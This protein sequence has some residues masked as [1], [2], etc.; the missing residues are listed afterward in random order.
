M[1]VKKGFFLL[2][3]VLVLF[4]V[5]AQRRKDVVLVVD[6]SSSMFSYYNELGTYLSGPFLAQNLAA[7]DTIHIISYGPKPRFEIVRQVVEQGDMETVSARIWLLY[8][9]SP[10]SDPAAALSYTEQYLRTIPGGRPKKVFIVSGDDLSAQVNAAAAR[11]Q[12]G[13]EM[14]FI[15]ASSLMGGSQPAA[16]GN[17]SGRTAVTAPGSS[18]GAAAAAPGSS[19]GTAT[20]APGRTTPVTT[21]GSSVGTAATAP[22][23]S[24]GTAAPAPGRTTPVTTPGSSA[25]TAAA[26]PGSSTGTAAPAPGR[27]TPAATPGSSAGTAAPAPGSS[28]GTAAAAP[29]SNSGRTTPVTAPS[30]S[31]GTAAAAPGSNSG[32]T[33]PAPAP[34]SSTGTAVAAPGSN[35]GRTAVATPDSSTG[36][37][38]A[39]SSGSSGTPAAVPDGSGTT[40][41]ASG[42]S[43]GGTAV[44]A[45]SG[46]SG[47][48]TAV[49][50]PDSSTGTV[51]AASGSN[52]GGTAKTVSSVFRNI[53]AIPRPILL[54]VGVLLLFLV[55][56]IIILRARSLHSSP[57]KVM[58][59]VNTTKENAK[60]L[61]SFASRQTEASLHGPR[62]RNQ[63]KD[64]G[65]FLTNPPML[66][67]FVEEQ[68]TAIGRRNI[69]SLKTG[70]TYSVGG[71]NS[72]FLI[73]LVPIPP[74]VGQLYFDGTN[75][76]FTPLKPEFFPDIGST[77][78]PEC[79][80]K[81]IRLIS[82]KSYEVFFH[83][84]RYIDP[85]IVMNQLLHSVQVP[86]VLGK[87]RQYPEGPIFPVTR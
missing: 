61:N 16:A 28:T 78:V 72:D 59:E 56:F 45:S 18:A 23:S 36:T 27:T 8:P 12:P 66:N 25:G 4:P 21:P 31:T 74:R 84:E 9:L 15:R 24:V 38:V 41:A 33:T 83:F 13:E 19:T 49:T 42:G 80:G 86:E 63:Y 75:C 70:S 51:A 6:T 79:I 58:A 14:Y 67:L 35:S 57:A 39:A 55:L 68:N 30:S 71:G 47:K 5:F 82:R 77:P 7:G 26:A 85:L 62:R 22:G 64:S 46:N 81:T 48:T 52:S 10:A 43:S 3:T 37:A 32:R 54:G 44:A 69:H 53:D 87:P 1:D 40:G 65:E 17:G 11:L 60:L 73:F 29:G 34:A 50:T 2:L 76:S 20:A